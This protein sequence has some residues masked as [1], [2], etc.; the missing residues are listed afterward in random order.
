MECEEAQR[1]IQEY[2]DGELTVWRVRAIVHH[3]DDC[4]PCKR[5]ATFELE[6]RALIIRKCSEVAP[7]D[8]Q[9]RIH[10]ALQDC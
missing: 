10:A 9:A 1:R 5:G 6:F 4:P 7:P 8:L 3:L 2:L